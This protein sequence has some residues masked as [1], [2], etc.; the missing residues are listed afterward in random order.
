MFLGLRPIVKRV[1]NCKDCKY[2]FKQNNEYYCKLFRYIYLI[3]NEPNN[4]TKELSYIR[5]DD[6]RSNDDLC[7]LGGNLF[8]EK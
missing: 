5:S 6:C 2:S 3:N 8:K 1:P 7:G 4:E